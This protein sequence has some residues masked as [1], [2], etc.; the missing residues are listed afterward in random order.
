MD[1]DK[2]ATGGKN[3]KREEVR[4]EGNTRKKEKEFSEE[5]EIRGAGGGE[6]MK[7]PGERGC[8]K[9]KLCGRKGEQGGTK[10]KD[11]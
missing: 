3:L 7:T 9:R 6:T 4:L 8:K 1:L 5:E 10:D 11:E 2:E